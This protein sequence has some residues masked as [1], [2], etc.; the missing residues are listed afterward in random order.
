MCRCASISQWMHAFYSTLVLCNQVTYFPDKASGAARFPTT[1]PVRALLNETDVTSRWCC[2][3]TVSSW[4]AHSRRWS[5][6]SSISS[7][8]C[9]SQKHARGVVWVQA[10]YY[11][12]NVSPG[13]FMMTCL[14]G[15]KYNNNDRT[16]IWFIILRQPWTV[17]YRRSTFHT[18][19]KTCYLC[20]RGTSGFPDW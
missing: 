3:H 7:D 4:A 20:C 11:K 13:V 16:S 2:W 12:D 10:A 18:C 14:P 1:K 19:T 8:T 9:T 17:P 15:A 6:F 5:L